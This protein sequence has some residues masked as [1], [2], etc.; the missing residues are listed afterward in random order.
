MSRLSRARMLPV[1]ID[2]TVSLQWPDKLK[3]DTLDYALDPSLW[4]Q[5]GGDLLDAIDVTLPPQSG[6]TLLWWGVVEGKAAIALTGGT[7]GLTTISVTLFTTA[8]RQHTLNVTLNVQNDNTTFLAPVPLRLP[9]NYCLPPSSLSNNGTVLTLEDG[10]P[11][12]L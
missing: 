2:P 10:S 3:S 8:G 9:G 7:P 4:L 11:L 12:T 6:L 5:D 1:P